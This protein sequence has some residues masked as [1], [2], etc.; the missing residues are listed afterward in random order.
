M[1]NSARPHEWPIVILFL[2][3]E[4]V[5]KRA[6]SKVFPEAHRGDATNFHYRD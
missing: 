1:P 4:W 3:S 2:R 5:L 6:V